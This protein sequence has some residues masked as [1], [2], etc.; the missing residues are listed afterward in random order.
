MVVTCQFPKFIILSIFKS[1]LVKGCLYQSHSLNKSI[2]AEIGF[3][4]FNEKRWPL[5]ILSY[6]FVGQP[7]SGWR[8]SG[9]QNLKQGS[10][11]VQQI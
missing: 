6:T 3:Q 7:Y 11:S 1:T 9:T 2:I 10:S 5:K 8:F 4:Y